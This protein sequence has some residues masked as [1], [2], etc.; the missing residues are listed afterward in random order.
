VYPAAGIPPTTSTLNIDRRAQTAAASVIVGT[1]IDGSIDLYIGPG[2]NVIVDILGWFTGAADPKSSDG[3]FVPLAPKRAIDTR[4]GDKPLASSTTAFNLPAVAGMRVVGASVNLTG[5]EATDQGYLTLFDGSTVP[6]VSNVNPD[7]PGATV[8]NHAF[9]A[10]SGTPRVFTS[11]G[12]HFA[13]DVDGVFVNISPGGSAITIAA[14][15]DTA[16]APGTA[17]TPTSCHHQQISDAILARTQ[18]TPAVEKLLLLGDLQYHSG[19]AAEFQGSYE[20]TYGRLKNITIPA[21]GNHE[22]NTPGATGYYGYFGAAAHGPNG[23]Y[24]VGLSPTWQVLVLNSNCTF[25]ACDASSAQ[26]AWVA[27]NVNNKPCTIATFHHP[28]FTSSPRGD[29][30]NMDPIWRLL[31]DRGATMVLN[32]HE[33]TYERFRPLDASGNASVKGLPEF[34][35]GTGGVNY[36]GY[37]SHRPNTAAHFAAFGYLELVLD[38]TNYRWSFVNEAG[39]TLDTGTASCRNSL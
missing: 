2:G 12:A 1:S 15:G 14:V 32:G 26:Y 23:Y 4:T 27:Q 36:Y 10:S 19:T 18:R 34:V 29:A 20:P 24:A 30:T 21:A 17:M 35:V 13:V 7:R 6:N 25:V 31:H 8:A 9:V 5:I 16:C 22:Y 38:T 11:S 33:H 3:L 39:A 37:P 28:R